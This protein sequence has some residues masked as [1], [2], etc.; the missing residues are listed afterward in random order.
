MLNLVEK[1]LSG[2][3]SAE[4]IE[5]MREVAEKAYADLV[6]STGAGNDFHGW[7]RL[8]ENY[9]KEEFARIKIAAEKIK[10]N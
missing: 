5:N 4:E 9:D 6:N 10:K 2:F 8:P 3:V 7:I 1:F